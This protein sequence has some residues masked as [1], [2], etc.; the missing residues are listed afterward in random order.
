MFIFGTVTN[1][2]EKLRS[3]A[4]FDVFPIKSTNQPVKIYVKSN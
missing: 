1:D 4:N 3:A 2:Y